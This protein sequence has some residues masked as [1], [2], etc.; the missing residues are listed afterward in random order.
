MQTPDTPTPAIDQHNAEIHENLRYWQRKPLLQQQYQHFYKEIAH[1]LDG[2]PSAPVLECGSGIGN[3]KSVLPEAITSDIFPNP[4]LDRQENVYALNYPDSSLGGIVLFDVFHHLEYPGTALDEL[5]RVLKP[6]GRVVIFE[7][8]AGLLGRIILGIFHHEPLGLNKPITLRAPTDFNPSEIHYYAAQGN[9][10]RI[11][12]DSKYNS[13]FARWK[14]PPAQYY[15]ALGWLLTGGF[16]GPSLCPPKC[17]PLV[18]AIDC[19][20]SL[21]PSFF[22]SR[23]LVVLEKT[24]RT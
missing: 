8:A 23:M 9:A 14:H 21:A 18:K 24:S 3:I 10:W 13:A 1:A 17:A 11:F 16:R 5:A 19:A 22:A 6:G 20:L 15:P 4:W 2:I 7:P 12:S